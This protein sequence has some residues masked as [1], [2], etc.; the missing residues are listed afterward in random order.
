MARPKKFKNPKEMQKAID[1][2]FAEDAYVV[3]NKQKRFQPTITGLCMALGC[4]RQT[5]L[6]YEFDERF[7]DTVKKAKMQ[8]EMA[9][10]RHLYGQSV[11]GAIFNLKNNF[12]WKDKTEQELNIGEIPD[13]NDY[14]DD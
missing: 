5:L 6:N 12:G 9:L 10:E 14:Y 4:C 11:T 3:I 8:V 1:K 13:I 2:Y 7:L